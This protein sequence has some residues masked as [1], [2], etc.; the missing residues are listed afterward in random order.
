MRIGIEVQRIFRPKK[1]GMEVVALELIRQLQKIDTENEYIIFAKND[2]DL[3]CLSETDN[4][5]IQIIPAY[6]YADWEQVKLPKAVK[7]AKLDFLHST[8]N[9]S[10]LR[11]STPLLLTLHDIIYL[12]KVEFKGTAYQNFGNLYRR[13]VVPRVVQKSDKI[14]TV[15]HF[16]RNTILER[17]RLPE[18]KVEVVYNAVSAA[19]HNRFAAEQINHFKEKHQLPE[20]FMLFLGNT[21]PKKNTPNVLAAYVAYCLSEKNAVP[22]AIL[23][24]D[25]SFVEEALNELGQKQLISHFVFPGYI[26]PHQ[27]PL[28]YN[29]AHL[30]LYPSLRESFGLPILEAMACGT[31]VITSTTSS[32]PEV[33]GGAAVLV[34]PNNHLDIAE[35]MH[36][37]LSD[38]KLYNEMLEKGLK[39]AADFTWESSADSLLALYNQIGK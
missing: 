4:F 23:D 15:S 30:F 12:E 20:K 11:Q 36:K 35:G 25:R 22:M 2:S 5:K 31:P 19:F 14:I 9:T 26:P 33:A 13:W 34:N 32:M 10:A 16:E 3:S 27:M 18:E 6:S 29:A 7:K 8:C 28:M 38:S 17:L 24:Y 21:A 39:R 1:H 37:L